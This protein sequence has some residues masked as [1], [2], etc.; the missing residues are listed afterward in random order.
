VAERLRAAEPPCKFL[1]VAAHI[2]VQ[3]GKHH[4]SLA[5]HSAAARLK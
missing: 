4:P 3:N 2:G 1:N 5:R